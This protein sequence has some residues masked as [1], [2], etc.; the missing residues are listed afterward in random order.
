MFVCVQRYIIFAKILFLTQ[1][2]AYGI[3]YP[4]LWLISI[5]PFRLLYAFTDFLTFFIYHILRY[6]RK[7]ISHNLNL[8]FPKK[9]RKKLK[10][11]QKK[12]YKHFT[13]IFL[14]MIKSLSISDKELKERFVIKNPEELTRLESLQKSYIVLRAHYASY[15]WVNALHFYGLSFKAYGVYKP[16]KNRYF[17]DLIKKLDLNTTPKC[18]PA[19]A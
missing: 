9:D 1:R 8:A 17:D 4:I 5:F 12:L 18:W 10:A 16:I 7:T 19:K 11:I 6:R 13:D 14:E 15:E 3:V 2:L